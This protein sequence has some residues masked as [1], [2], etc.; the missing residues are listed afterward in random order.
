MSDIGIGKTAYL[1]FY[2]GGE[3]A[4]TLTVELENGE[5]LESIGHYFERGLRAT[6]K[7]TNSKINQEKKNGY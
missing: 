2:N 3:N 5:I 4:Y 7:I 6:E 1:G